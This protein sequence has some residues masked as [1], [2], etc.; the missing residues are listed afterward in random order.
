MGRVLQLKAGDAYSIRMSDGRYT[1]ARVLRIT[2]EPCCGDEAL[3]VMAATDW[4]GEQPPTLPMA[5]R[6]EVLAR[7]KPRGEQRFAL[8]FISRQNG[9][10]PAN[11]KFIG[12]IEPTEW[13]QKRY[14]NSYSHW[15]AFEADVLQEEKARLDPGALEEEN[16]QHRIQAEQHQ[17][18]V[19]KERQAR[20]ASITIEQLLKEKPFPDWYELPPP[21]IKRKVVKLYRKALQALIDL[22]PSAS[23]DEKVAAFR[24]YIE[25]LN[26]LEVKTGFIETDEREDLL[27]R[28]EEMAH[29]AGIPQV[30]DLVLEWTRDW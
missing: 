10:P 22:G 9:K 12:T 25:A 8:T 21:E 20:L 2:R 26:D 14:C 19:E 3:A 6:P 15:Y 28:A 24:E 5:T 4:I 29:A 18:Q 11:F 1:I 7:S 27:T 16:R 13:E 30:M 23:L 17:A